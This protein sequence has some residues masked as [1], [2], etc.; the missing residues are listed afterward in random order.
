MMKV[1]PKINLRILK[2][3]CSFVLAI[4]FC[5]PMCAL[6]SPAHAAKSTALPNTLTPEM[7]A[8]F[9]DHLLTYQDQQGEYSTYFAAIETLGPNKYPVLR[10][11]EDM[12][13]AVQ[14]SLW[15]FSG[16]K[17]ENVYNNMANGGRYDDGTFFISTSDGVDYYGF[18]QYV[19]DYDYDNQSYAVYT[20]E[21]GQWKSK[22]EFG[23]Y[24][25]S[26]V[27]YGERLNTI[28]TFSVTENGNEKSIS[29]AEFDQYLN[30]YAGGSHFENCKNVCDSYLAGSLSSW[31]VSSKNELLTPYSLAMLLQ[32]SGS[33]SAMAVPNNHDDPLDLLTPE[34]A[35]AYAEKLEEALWA[36]VD[37][38]GTFSASIETVEG[39]PVL[40]ILVDSYPR[41]EEEI[42]VYRSGALQQLDLSYSLGEIP[43]EIPWEENEKAARLAVQLKRFSLNTTSYAQFD[44]VLPSIDAKQLGDAEDRVAF[45]AR[46]Y[47]EDYEFDSTLLD[48][49]DLADFALSMLA[50]GAGNVTTT[51]EDFSTTGYYAYMVGAPCKEIQSEMMRLVGRTVDFT[52]YTLDHM[53]QPG[54][55]DDFQ[56]FVY[57]DTAY[58][59]MYETYE[60]STYDAVFL[61]MYDLGNEIFIAPAYIIEAEYGYYLHG[62][63]IS[64]FHKNEQDYQL[65]K[66][67]PLNK[68]PSVDEINR[69]AIRVNPEP[70]F[71][72]DY[73]V[74]SQYT[75]LKQYVE[76][77]KNAL[78]TTDRLNDAGNRAV[79][80]Y[81]DFVIQNYAPA[82]I[83]ANEN[84][85]IISPETVK[86]A[87]LSAIEAK[88]TL[89]DAIGGLT[90]SRA[91][92][93][94]ARIDVSGLDLTS[95]VRVRLPEDAVAAVDD[96][97][98]VTLVLGDSQHM[99]T[100]P[101]DG[102]RQT[103]YL[104]VQLEQIGQD[105]YS[106][107]FF[108]QSDNVIE[109][110]ETNITFTLPASSE[111]SSVQA[112]C[113]GYSDNWGGQYDGQNKTITFQTPY[114][115]EY[116]VLTNTIEI[117]DI[118]YLSDEMQQAIT[119]MVSKG[120]FDLDSE[121]RFNPSVGL[122]RYEFTQALVKVFFAL[123][124]DAETSFS[125]V[126]RDN[127]YYP[128]VASGEENEI[129]AGYDDGLFHG[130]DDILRVQMLAICGRTLANKKGYSRPEDPSAYLN[131]VDS[132][133]IP[134]WS[135]ND[136][137]LTVREGLI[138]SGSALRPNQAINRGEAALLLYRLFM[139]LYEVSPTPITIVEVSPSQ[140]EIASSGSISPAVIGGIAVVC[141]GG[142]GVAAYYI[143]LGK[144]KLL[145]KKP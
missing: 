81:I 102:L 29:E 143:L 135:A 97:D 4:V 122:N 30:K 128:Y 18:R 71:K 59:M 140:T 60:Y 63:Y 66:L 9:A 53:P 28:A 126:T 69:Y 119:F 70:N 141:V 123:D 31:G 8:A 65:L 21:S 27:E 103:G 83:P 3:F 16:G 133:D 125:D 134:D 19:G 93:L 136:L 33:S 51:G 113:A 94:T 105:Q 101:A 11:I 85:A 108:D 80:D 77:L 79:T 10:I 32:S 41:V 45:V 55:V 109:R 68:F 43:Q 130:D 89:M 62:P 100:I 92:T 58:F 104:D 52:S 84:S 14:E 39:L 50:V 38:Y 132:A 114:T 7:A 86:A 98:A 107:S 23:E 67:Y 139:L 90:L 2:R 88:E 13:T 144:K 57:N 76:A 36:Y 48:N 1:C 6:P 120:Y 96:L 118:D 78:A 64:V 20:V 54:E 61:E 35:K 26:D 40:R 91:P 73:G 115:G 47:D 22:I 117:P 34:I 116:T 42:W 56:L 49:D 82:A 74:I 142:T 129:L 25:K 121:G 110:L 95:P 17:L 87:Q 106:I 137:A 37:S 44:D 111:L 46:P 99:V 72:V 131:Y 12:E 5:V 75:D 15:L 145:S 112:V 138:E 124:L 127:P 24:T